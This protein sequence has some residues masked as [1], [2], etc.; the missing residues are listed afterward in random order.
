VT[1]TATIDGVRIAYERRGTGRPLVLLHGGSGNREHGDRLAEL[2]ANAQCV[3]TPDLPGHRRSAR[4]SGRYGLEPVATVVAGFVAAVVGEPAAVYGHSY[5]GH[6]A[7]VLAA[8]HPDVVRA[9][10]IGDAPLSAPAVCA[11]IESARPGL[12]LW[13]SLAA[14]GASMEVV[15][16]RLREM[17]VELP[18]GTSMP[19]RDV[20]GAEDPWFERMAASL[21]D[22]D[23]EF[24]DA[25]LERCDEVHRALDPDVLLPRIRGPVLMLQG[26]PEA[27]GLVPDRDVEL[28]HRLL[29]GIQVA[30][31]AGVGHGLHTER[32]EPIASA[33]RDFLR[34]S[35]P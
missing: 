35:A 15:A 4:T 18:D 6:V 32:P 1:R 5:G 23:P 31:V 19:A 10:V 9:A 33:I 17:P 20:L 25:I 21:L 22:H 26:D 7:L 34:V 2:L 24:L 12:E 16:D 30:R 13:R 3:Y 29:P 8:G 11:L 28:A 14:S 27:G